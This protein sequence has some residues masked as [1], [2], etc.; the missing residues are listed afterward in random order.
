M[1]ALLLFL[2]LASPQE[3]SAKLFASMTPPRATQDTAPASTNTEVFK[4]IVIAAGKSATLDST[5][6]Y[7]SADIVAVTVQCSICDSATTSLAASGLTLQA[8]W[9]IPE[10][11]VSVAT[12]NKSASSF[13][14]WDAGGAIFT[15][16]GPQFRLVL[17]NRG[18][19]AIAIQQVTIFRRN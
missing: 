7:S 8:R 13:P 16:F 17:Q 5:L 3:R 4:D 1:N 12:E 11:V 6:D 18:K 9:T 15:V 2:L 19:D 14:Y 10:A